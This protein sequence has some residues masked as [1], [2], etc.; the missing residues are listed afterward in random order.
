MD[1]QTVERELREELGSS[2]KAY[3]MSNAPCGYY[4]YT[5]PK[6]AQEKYNV[7]SSKVCQR[8]NPIIAGL[9]AQ[10]VFFYRARH[11]DG[12]IELHKNEGLVDYLW[13]T[14]CELKEYFTPE[15]YSRVRPLLNEE[16]YIAELKVE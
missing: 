11:V 1:V 5:F 15:Y 7:E 16:V 4:H 13:V 9:I 14:C 10:Q 6:P 2:L 3:F 12:E 8:T